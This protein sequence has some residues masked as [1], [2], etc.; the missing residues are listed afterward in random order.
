MVWERND[1]GTD[2][3]Y[4]GWVHLAVRVGVKLG[5][6]L[7]LCLVEVGDV[8]RDHGRLFLFDIQK[9]DKAVLEG[10]IEVHLATFQ[11]RDVPLLEQDLVVIDNK[12]RSLHSSSIRVETNLFVGNITDDGDLFWDLIG[13]PEGLHLSHQ[14]VG[15]V[16]RAKPVSIHEDFHVFA[17]PNHVLVPLFELLD[18]EV[19]K[20]GDKAADGA[21]HG[22]ECHERKVLDKTTSCSLWSLSWTDHAPMSVVELARFGEFA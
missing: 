6:L 12:E 21:T 10:V 1:G 8:H 19:L 13:S 4:H 11:G 5:F 9:L 22:D 16:V 7:L 14:D 20:N 15:V 18:S 3:K 2:T 17:G